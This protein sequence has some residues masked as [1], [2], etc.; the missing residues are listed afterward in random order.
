MDISRKIENMFTMMGNAWEYK[1]VIQK[2]NINT[3]QD[4]NGTETTEEFLNEY[5]VC[6]YVTLQ[7]QKTT[8]KVGFEKQVIK[9]SGEESSTEYDKTGADIKTQRYSGQLSTGFNTNYDNYIWNY[10]LLDGIHRTVDGTVTWHIGIKNLGNNVSPE[11]LDKKQSDV[12]KASLGV[13]NEYLPI[14]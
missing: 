3:W 9:N 7:K 1:K 11:N 6:S 10:P 12:N 8:T 14:N 2:V 13:I 5:K 4:T